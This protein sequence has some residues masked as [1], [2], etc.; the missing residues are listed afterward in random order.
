MKK[1]LPTAAAAVVMG[2]SAFFFFTGCDSATDY[3]IEVT[4]AWSEVRSVG[5]QV[6][7]SATGWGDYNWSLSN[8][9]YGYLSSTHGERVVYTVTRIP[10]ATT[11]TST[12]NQNTGSVTP[13]MQVVTVKGRNMSGS[14]SSSGVSIGTN[15]PAANNN[16]TV[17][18]GTAR[19]QHSGK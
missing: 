10:V 17:Y 1:I 14:S 8:P 9:D 19:I 7:L 16:A 2:L 15:A 3:S 13:V 12:N 4:P 11:T 6:S 5:Q 18:S